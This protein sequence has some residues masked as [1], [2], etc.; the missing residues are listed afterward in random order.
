MRYLLG[1]YEDRTCSSKQRLELPLWACTS[2][3]ADEIGCSAY[4]GDPETHI[5]D[6]EVAISLLEHGISAWCELIARVHV[7][8]LLLKYLDKAWR[9]FLRR[10]V[11]RLG[12]APPPRT[13][14]TSTI[15]HLSELGSWLS[16]PS[17]YA[18][19]LHAV[20]SF[21][22]FI[23]HLSFCRC[24]LRCFALSEANW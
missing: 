9:S 23:F 20:C 2:L 6:L 7:G 5:P 19:F 4:A 12:S 3:L 10:F 24:A 18:V 21:F 15:T 17:F 16:D 22:S 1:G 14:Q 11:F 8:H 13:K